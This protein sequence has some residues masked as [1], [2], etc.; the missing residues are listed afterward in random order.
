M[1]PRT[2]AFAL[3]SALAA[4]SSLA[5]AD[6]APSP[7]ETPARDEHPRRP[8]SLALLGGYGFN[9][10]NADGGGVMDIYGAGFGARGGYTFSPGVYLG[11]SYVYHLGFT[12]DASPNGRGDGRVAPLGAEAGYDFDLGAV[13]LRPYVGAGVVFYRSSYTLDATRFGQGDGQKPALWPGLVATASIGD[14]LFAGVDLR[15]YAVL[16]GNDQEIVGLGGGS[17][18]AFATYA[19]LGFRV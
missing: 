14:R 9:D 15:Y 2:T 3:V 1:T 5:H 16:R 11:A 12:R 10:S 8:L 7:A 6:P 17:A 13:T 19:T 18:N 4:F